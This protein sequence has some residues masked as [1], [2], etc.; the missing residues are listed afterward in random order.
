MGPRRLEWRNARAT[1]TVMI[2]LLVAMFAGTMLLAHFEG[3]APVESQ[4][5]LS[6]LGHRAFGA[7]P[8]Y[9]FLQAA[10]ALVL[11][12]AANT[13]FS[14]FPRLLFFLA[15]DGNAPRSFLHMGDRLAF[16]RGLTLLRRPRRRCSSCS[17]GAPRR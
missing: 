8:L 16:T 10:T 14:D 5:L 6:Q 7:G 4:T 3:V 1:L 9:V 12:F 11:L 2:T 17:A 15:R 13:A